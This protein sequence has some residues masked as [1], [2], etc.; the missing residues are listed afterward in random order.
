MNKNGKRLLPALLLAVVA[1]SVQAVEDNWAVV[2]QDAADPAETVACLLTTPHHTL[3]DGQGDT[4]LWLE[5]DKTALVV[6]TKSSID[7]EFKDVGIQVDQQAFIPF[8]EIRHETDVAFSKAIKAITQQ[9]ID[10]HEVVVSLRFWPTWPTTG[11]KRAAFS[12]SGFTS[13]YQQVCQP[14]TTPTPGVGQAKEEVK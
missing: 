5:V 14:A 9:F 10:G 4:T 12:L 13:A 8:D 2:P 3:N 7:T 1:H 11:V 6:K